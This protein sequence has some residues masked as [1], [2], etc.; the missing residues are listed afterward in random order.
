MRLGEVLALEWGDVD[1]H[2]QYIL[3]QRAFRHVTSHVDKK[4][5]GTSSRYVRSISFSLAGTIN[6]AKAGRV[7]SG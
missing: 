5:Q 3:V 4:Q 1:W 2:S 6:Q 7:G